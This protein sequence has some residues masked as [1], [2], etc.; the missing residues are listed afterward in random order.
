MAGNGVLEQVWRCSPRLEVPEP[1]QN[2][3]QKVNFEEDMESK[4]A[5]LVTHCIWPLDV[6]FS[7]WLDEMYGHVMSYFV[8][9]CFRVTHFKY[10]Q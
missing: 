4:G 1:P 10:G 9:F 2:S 5:T 8:Q 7:S 3:V 6:N